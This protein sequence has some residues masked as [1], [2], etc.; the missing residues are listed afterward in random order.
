MN[1]GDPFTGS[2]DVLAVVLEAIHQQAEFIAD[3]KIDTPLAQGNVGGLES[4]L[5]GRSKENIVTN[6]SAL[7]ALVDD[8]DENTYRLRDYLA[9]AHE[10]GNGEAIGTDLAAELAHAEKLLA[11]LDASIEDIVGG[12]DADER[13]ALEAIGRVFH[14]ISLLGEDAAVAAGVQLGFTHDDGD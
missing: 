8:E 13:E 7:Q 11:A 2:D 14:R 4:Y 12:N 3:T 9:R 1:V 5:A 10:E 6:V